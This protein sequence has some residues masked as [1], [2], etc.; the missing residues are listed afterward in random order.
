MTEQEPASGQD[1]PEPPGRRTWWRYAGW[2]FLAVVCLAGGHLGGVAATQL[3]PAQVTTGEISADVT[4]DLADANRVVVDT[5][6]GDVI[7]V[8]D[9]GFRA[10]GIRI[11]PRVEGALLED[12]ENLS[13]W[14]L[15]DVRPLAGQAATALAVRYGVGALVGVLLAGLL[16]HTLRPVSRRRWTIAALAMVGVI[17]AQGIGMTRTYTVQNYQAYRADGLLGAA[18]AEG[19]LTGTRLTERT[20]GLAKYLGRWQAL[21]RDLD[22]PQREGQNLP[23]MDGP[24][25]LLVSDIHGINGAP[26]IQQLVQS[27]QVSAVI[28]TGDLLNAGYV[29]EAELTGIFDGIQNLGVPYIFV[30]GNHDRRSAGDRALVERMQQI[31]NVTLLMPDRETFNLVEVGGVRIAGVND[32]LRWFGDSD[33]DNARKQVQFT[34]RFNEQFAD[35]PPDLAITHEPSGA[36]RMKAPLRLAGHFHRPSIARDDT[37]AVI[38]NGTLTGGGIFGQNDEIKKPGEVTGQTVMILT[39]SGDCRDVVLRTIEFSGQLD[40]QFAVNRTSLDYLP[41]SDVPDR[42]CTSA[43]EATVTPVTVTD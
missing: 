36:R 22:Q 19:Q 9:S 29:Q 35:A 24:S 32:E 20:D 41:G 27:N 2:V 12:S 4:L 38:T 13:E 17:G 14:S 39:Y 37:G 28:D 23:V 25:F 21:Q 33:T 7:V 8:F 40:G 10:S 43:P 31:P 18:L 1:S 34:T 6:L 3:V 42:T 11:S 16:V 30:L 26:V 5:T 15:D